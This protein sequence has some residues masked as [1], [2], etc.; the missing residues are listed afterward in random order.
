MNRQTLNDIKTREKKRQ[1][2]SDM[3]KDYNFSIYNEHIK[4][5]FLKA[6]II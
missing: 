2:R 6:A 3:M 5:V 1:G 4:T